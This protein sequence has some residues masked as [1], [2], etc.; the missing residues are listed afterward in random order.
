MVCCDVLCCA[1]RVVYDRVEAGG[2]NERE[3]ECT[4]VF[5]YLFDYS[6]EY[7]SIPERPSVPNFSCSSN[8]HRRSLQIF[9]ISPDTERIPERSGVH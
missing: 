4:T 9:P 7:E 8:H 5:A 2:G 3:R 1:V 6:N